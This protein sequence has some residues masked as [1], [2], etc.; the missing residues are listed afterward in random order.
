[1]DQAQVCAL[2]AE[3]LHKKPRA[4]TLM[5]FGHNSITYDVTLAER[6]VIVRMNRQ[7]A[8]FARTAANLQILRELGLPVPTV[9]TADL[10]LRRYPFAYLILAK[11]PGR[12]L[13]YELPTMR[14][15]QITRLAGQIV[16]FQQLVA[17]LPPGRGFGYVPIGERGR[18]T[19]WFELVRQE[20]QATLPAPAGIPAELAERARRLLEGKLRPYLM[21][22][23]PI[24]FL[25]DL[26]VKNVIVADGELQGLVDFDGVCYGD[27]CFAIGLTATGIV[28]DLVCNV[29]DEPLAYVEALCRLGG[30]DQERRA[31]VALYAALFAIDFVRREQ[32]EVTPAWLACMSAATE[33]WLAFVEQVET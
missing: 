11:I 24:C 6:N 5:T 29:G 3:E 19:S 32:G 8:V 30:L 25:D 17:G 20:T 31:A 4:A 1:M 28:C 9:I 23:Q 18:Y 7:P 27:W 13:R 16:R 22:I 33:R 10:T 15:E 21:Q 2:V 26:T 14:P 12:D